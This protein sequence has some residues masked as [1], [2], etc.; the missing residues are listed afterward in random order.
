MSA[1][2]SGKLSSLFDGLYRAWA[3]SSG[4]K[5]SSEYTFGDVGTTRGAAATDWMDVIPEA[6]N[7]TG[8]STLYEYLTSRDEQRR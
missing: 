5:K 6:I 4:Q 2:L 1:G 8:L 3:L 7:R